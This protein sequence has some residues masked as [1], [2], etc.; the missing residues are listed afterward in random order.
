[1]K[2]YGEGRLIHREQSDNGI[3]EVVDE[4]DRRS[5]HFGTYPKQSC[6][7]LAKPYALMLGYTKA[8]MASLIFQPKPQR[9]LIIGL[10]GGSLVKFLLHHFSDC[11]I[12]VVELRQD[13]INIARRFFMVPTHHSQL[14][15][16]IDEGYHF[17]QQQF[18]QDVQGYDMILVDAYDHQSMAES[19]GSQAFF[20]ACCSLLKQNGVMG[21]NLWG[22]GG[23]QP[24]VSK[25]KNSFHAGIATLPV[26]DRG[27]IIAFGVLNP[28]TTTG[29]KK[30][31]ERVKVLEQGYL[32]GLPQ[33]LQ[34][35]IRR[36]HRLHQLLLAVASS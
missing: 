25:I 12:D 7:S 18:Y 34:T 1:M 21:I 20:D 27:N 5:L 24:I 33:S 4:G 36:N 16:Y 23:I 13:V 17:V 30:Q 22:G 19:V 8:M 28:I 2:L 6:M 15:L 35:I 9:V 3:I 14:N 32:I 10:G 26:P 31:R 29:L 11:H